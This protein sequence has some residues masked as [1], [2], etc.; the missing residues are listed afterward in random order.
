MRKALLF[1]SLF[2]LTLLAQAAEQRFISIGT[3]W[4]EPGST[5]RPGGAICRLIKAIR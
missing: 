5:I 3:R 2:S 1:M 4:A